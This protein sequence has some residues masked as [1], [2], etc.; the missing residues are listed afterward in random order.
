MHELKMMC[1]DDL[2]SFVPERVVE[3]LDRI[4]RDLC[5]LTKNDGPF[6]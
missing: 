6:L 1:N 5:C 3:F 2:L 4:V